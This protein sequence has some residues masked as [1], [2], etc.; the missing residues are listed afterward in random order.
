MSESTLRCLYCGGPQ[1][2]EHPACPTCGAIA[3]FVTCD[4]CKAKVPAGDEKCR[5]GAPLDPNAK[6]TAAPPC[7]RCQGQS[8]VLRRFGDGAAALQCESCH[9]CFVRVRDWSLIVDDSASG[10]PVDT[11][12]FV[13]AGGP[14]LT[15]NQLAE[16]TRCPACGRD[17]D[18][19]HFGVNSPA[20]VDVCETHGMWL[21]AGE[22]GT[23]LAVAAEVAKA[24]KLPAESAADQAADAALSARLRAE[25]AE[26]DRNADIARANFRA[27]D[28]L[29]SDTERFERWGGVLND[30]VASLPKR[31]KK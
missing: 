30:F 19:F 29:Y 13:V 8:L 20:V 14:R 6:T 1:T 15:P 7:P 26:V 5:C 9:G 4:K 31:L 17:M 24:G 10:H 21:D 27:A 2:A 18:R 25:E 11:K 28:I 3:R 16:T 12:D 22:L 23:V